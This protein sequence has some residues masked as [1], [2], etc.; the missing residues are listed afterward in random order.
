MTTATVTLN[1]DVINRTE[2]IAPSD[3][4]FES[5]VVCHLKM[6]LEDMRIALYDWQ[7]DLGS[8]EVCITIREHKNDRG[9]LYISAINGHPLYKQFVEAREKDILDYV[10]SLCELI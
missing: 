4:E 9:K 10:L 1:Q 6:D 5:G 7:I 3:T 8:S 2:V